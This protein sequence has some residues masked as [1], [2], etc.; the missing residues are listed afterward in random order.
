MITTL[1][2]EEPAQLRAAYTVGTIATQQHFI[3][4]CAEPNISKVVV[5]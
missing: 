2:R 5:R 1:V 4:Y 3:T